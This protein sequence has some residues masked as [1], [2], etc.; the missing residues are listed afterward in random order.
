MIQIF[1][2]EDSENQM[3]AF[4]DTFRERF[5]SLGDTQAWGSAEDF[6]SEWL[7]LEH[8]EPV[9]LLELIPVWFFKGFKGKI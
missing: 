6:H 5:I 8:T 1:L 9:R 7:E 4:F 3:F 2:S